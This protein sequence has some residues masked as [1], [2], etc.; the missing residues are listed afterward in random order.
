MSFLLPIVH[1][2]VFY[3]IPFLNVCLVVLSRNN[4]EKNLGK[5]AS[6]TVLNTLTLPCR[7]PILSKSLW[8]IVPSV[9]YNKDSHFKARPMLGYFLQ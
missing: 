4:L 8:P 1:L 6:L 7:I 9:A 3:R 5:I 2:T